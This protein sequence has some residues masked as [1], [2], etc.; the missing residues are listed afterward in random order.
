MNLPWPCALSG[1]LNSPGNLRGD[2]P[3]PTP[4]ALTILH[5]SNREKECPE[6]GKEEENQLPTEEGDRAQVADHGPQRDGGRRQ[7]QLRGHPPAHAHAARP[8]ADAV[9]HCHLQRK[10]S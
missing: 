2:P 3:P 9:V 5:F 10:E 8:A 4:V 7:L 6:L 1:L